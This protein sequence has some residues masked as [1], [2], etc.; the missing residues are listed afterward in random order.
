MERKVGSGSRER[1]LHQLRPGFLLLAAQDPAVCLSSPQNGILDEPDTDEVLFSSPM[2]SL[3]IPHISL[4]LS[5][6]SL[7]LGKEEKERMHP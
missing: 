7:P 6:V 2:A 4:A 3:Q 5:H 1:T